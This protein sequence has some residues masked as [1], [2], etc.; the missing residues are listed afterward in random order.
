MIFHFLGG[1]SL[2][3]YSFAQAPVNQITSLIK[4]SGPIYTPKVLAKTKEENKKE[5]PKKFFQIM[6]IT[7]IPVAGYILLAPF[8]YKIFFPQYTEAIIYSQIYML[9]LLTFGKKFIGVSSMVH[10]PQKTLYKLS[11]INPMTDIVIKLILLYF[12]GLV[13][14]II[15]SVISN[16]IVTIISF[17]YFKRM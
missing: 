15:A 4:L 5:L 11:I 10:L 2:A 6:F 13:G 9:T 3:V 1:S 14:A 12:F 7:I 8:F 16:A 17:Y